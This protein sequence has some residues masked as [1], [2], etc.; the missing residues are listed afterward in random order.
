M[1]DVRRRAAATPPGAHG[2]PP[3]SPCAKRRQR[4]SAEQA[5]L[6]FGLTD[7]DLA[8]LSRPRLRAHPDDPAGRPLKFYLESEVE[9]RRF[10][11]LL[12]LAL[13]SGTV[14]RQASSG[15]LH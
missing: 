14:K 5:K 4:I 13:F 6:I 1:L 8:R 12:C 11:P 7:K 9:V 2:T 10:E 15:G 3:P